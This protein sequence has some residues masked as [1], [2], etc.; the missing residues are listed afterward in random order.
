M[1]ERGK[2]FNPAEAGY[3]E[4]KDRIIAFYAKYPN[5]SLQ[6][7]MIELG[8]DIVVM[9]GYAYRTPDDERPGIGHSQMPIPGKTPYTKDS[10]IENAET[11]AWGRAIAALGFEVKKSI[12]SADEVAMK[13]GESAE[14]PTSATSPATA[15]GTTEPKESPGAA[16][17]GKPATPAQKRKLMAEGRKLFGSEEEVRKFVYKTVSKNRSSDLTMDDMNVLFEKMDEAKS[18]LDE[19]EAAAVA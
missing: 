12:A 18:V 19:A 5:G 6:S 3:I 10:E 9:K 11:S 1:T 13:A 4:V 14:D 8:E 7:E 2:A 15:L 17:I 16:G